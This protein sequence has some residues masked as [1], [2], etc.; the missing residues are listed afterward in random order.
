LI[1]LHKKNIMIN[2]GNPISQ[3]KMVLTRD[4]LGIQVEMTEDQIEKIK[5]E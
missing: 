1:Q 5:L 4:K 3:Q 2:N